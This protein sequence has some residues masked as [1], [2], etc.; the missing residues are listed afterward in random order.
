MMTV[1]IRVTYTKSDPI[2]FTGHL[3]LQRIW[4]RTLR[5][6]RLPVAYSHG[7]NPQARIQIACALPLGFT[8]QCELLDFWLE[9][10]RPLAE[11]EQAVAG[12]VPPGIE[13]LHLTEVDAHL[14]ALQTQVIA[15][16]YRVSLLDPYSFSDLELRI[17]NLLS[18]PSLCRTWREKSYDLR[19]LV[20]TLAC[21]PA[22]EGNPQIIMRLSARQNATGRPEEVLSALGL[23]PLLAHYDRTHLFLKD[24]P[25]A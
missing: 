8:S 5:R 14:P 19:L 9:V 3:D 23:D 21:Y 10:E 11:I 6:S 16:Q 12:A 20:E 24:F 17:Q 1:R 15:A 13:I 2:R 4:E 18:A 7:F 22:A 25:S